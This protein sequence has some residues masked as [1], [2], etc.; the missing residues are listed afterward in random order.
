MNW[1][2]WTTIIWSM[3]VSTCLTLI[4]LHL[5]IWF[6]QPRQWAHLSF[7][8]FAAAVVVVTIMEF[9]AMH[10]ATVEQMSAMLR[11]AHLPIL[12]FFMAIAC[13]V[14]CF[15]VA[16]R[17]S[18]AWIACGL[19]AFTLVLGFTTGANQFFKEITGLKKVKIFGGETI[20]V[21]EGILNSWYIVGPLS[22]LA[23]IIFVLDASITMWRRGSDSDRRRVMFFSGGIISFLIIA[24]GHA[25]L[26]NA[27]FI[28]SPYIVG[29]S[30]IP[31]IFATS[32]ELS[33]EVLRAARLSY[34]L[35]ASEAELR[36]SEQRMTLAAD[37]AKLGMWEWNIAR[38]EIWSTDKGLGLFGI[39]KQELITFDYFMNIVY[40]ED[41]NAVKQ[42]L[43]KAL[44]G[45]GDYEIEYRIMLPDGQLRWL[46]AR[47]CVEFDTKSPLRMYGVVIDIGRR[48]QAELEAQRQRNELA[49][50][51]RVNL[52][53]ELSGSLAHELNQ[54]LAAI[55]S[56]AQA[57]LRFLAHDNP[58]LDEVRDILND[59]VNED[60][61]AG[62]VIHR[63]RLLLKKGEVQQQPF[64]L[65]DAVQDVLKLLRGDFLNYNVT[66]N[67]DLAPKL[68]PVIGDR[69]QIQQVLLNLL[70]NGC[71]AMA[72][73]KI[74]KRQFHIK[75]RLKGRMV[76]M[77]IRD[78]G[79]GIAPENMES[80]FE[81]FF[82]TKARGMGLGLPICRSI[83]TFHGGQL[84]ATNNNGD[85]VSFYFTLPVYSEV[86]V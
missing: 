65:N 21:A 60:K 11:W 35:Q 67:I 53:G 76:Q 64:D 22:A 9:I 58:S 2:S 43:E 61:R 12:I 75:S 10:A 84:W 83:V 56:N 73:T 81:P 40:V 74:I 51:A 48:K 27:G 25:A 54:P 44:N 82:T 70:V 34:R 79:Q 23:L 80:I 8:M 63:L 28:D 66:V 19:Q 71:E 13:F 6:R 86:N 17:L 16:G 18:L 31:T 72:H 52:M 68:P 42:A 7:S 1:L 36:R 30:F 77:S 32:F 4:S 15:F 85:G 55:L 5:F 62:E 26:V 45:N 78:Q 69:V 49:H 24:P 57:A 37:A 3:M 50:L 38:D 47:G 59:I 33:S 14:R 39:S 29:F 41:R 46:A 20:S